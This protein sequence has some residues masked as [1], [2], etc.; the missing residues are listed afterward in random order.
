MFEFVSSSL[1]AGFD[2]YVWMLVLVQAGGGILVAA[3]I[4]FADNILKG[5]ATAIAIVANGLVSYFL[6][7]FVP[8]GL[9]LLGATIVVVS[10]VLYSA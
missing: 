8:S 2:S 3:V 5:F 10:T 9:F 7:D 6:F 4:K 1:F